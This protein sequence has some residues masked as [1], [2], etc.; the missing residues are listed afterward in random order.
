MGDW[1]AKGGSQETPGVTGKIGLGVQNDGG[2]RL[3]D[4]CQEN[5]LDTLF[6]QNKGKLYTWTSPD[7]QHQ[8]QI[9]YILWSQSWR[10]SIQSA[11]IRP[12]ADGGSAHELLT[13]K[14]RLKLKKVGE[15]TRSFMYDLKQI[16]Y[17]Y[18]VE[19]TNRFNGLD[20]IECLMKFGQRSVTLYRRQGSRL[21][22]R[23]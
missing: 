19:L 16:A 2:Q 6:Q 22:P 3:T 9:D 13:G 8:N 4:F 7:G 15:T 11:K 14:F 21:S 23:K 5:S 10:N 20:Q 17:G 18:T 12:G 1:K